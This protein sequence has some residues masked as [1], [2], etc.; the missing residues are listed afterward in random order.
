MDDP[1]L[2]AIRA[3]LRQQM[4]DEASVPDGAPAEAAPP[5]P[6]TPLLATDDGFEALVR[7]HRLLVVDCWAP[8]CGPCR[9]LG[10]TIDELAREM[11]GTV[12]FAKLDVDQNPRVSNAFGIR[13]IP[14]L[15][16]FKEGRLVDQIVGV[17]AK[18]ALRQALARHAGRAGATPGP[19]R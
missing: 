16:I 9:I 14:T 10:P 11:A 8:W 7:E 12:V 4:L 17:P 3:R 6:S 18:P 2:E 19:R 15:L 5:A 13:S 1:E